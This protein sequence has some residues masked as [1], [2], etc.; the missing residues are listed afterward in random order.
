MQERSEISEA[1]VFSSR[2][3]PSS[4]V[5]HE[6]AQNRPS[7]SLRGAAYRRG[8]ELQLSCCSAGVDRGGHTNK[9]R[10]EGP[11]HLAQNSKAGW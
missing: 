6:T 9:G 1:S 2:R 10:P 7:L 3:L 8:G 5:A 4:V 11:L